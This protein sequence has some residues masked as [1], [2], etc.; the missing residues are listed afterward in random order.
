MKSLCSRIKAFI[1]RIMKNINR[2]RLFKLRVQTALSLAVVSAALAPLTMI[3]A[4]EPT[5]AK[6]PKTE[7]TAGEAAE[8]GSSK[9]KPTPPPRELSG[10]EPD[11][12][13]RKQSHPG[14]QPTH[15]NAPPM[16]N[17]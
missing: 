3:T 5:D 4:A 8:A 12:M 17:H 14:P 13:D 2:I 15:G 11:F 1:Y 9:K 7:K 16:E 10:A 6:A